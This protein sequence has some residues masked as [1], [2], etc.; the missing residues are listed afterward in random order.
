MVSPMTPASSPI[1]S[2]R[3]GYG[4][5]LILGLTMAETFLLLVFCL[6]LI[7]AASI[8]HQRKETD[9]AVAER[10][11]VI[12]K[13]DAALGDLHRYEKEEEKLRRENTLLSEKNANLE[14]TL[15]AIPE[16]KIA[17]L[18]SVSSCSS[19]AANE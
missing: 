4:R 14:S 15:N 1:S 9:R 12:A 18:T 7:A 17:N 10:D 3:K 16:E 6:M 8:I 13:L 5:G 2:E 19:A 11:T